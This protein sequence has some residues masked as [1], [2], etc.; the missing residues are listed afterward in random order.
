[1]GMS[2]VEKIAETSNSYYF[3]SLKTAQLA[4]LYWY[5]L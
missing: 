2:L 5:Y 1:M 3:V 4:L